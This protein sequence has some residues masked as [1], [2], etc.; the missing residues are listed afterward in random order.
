MRFRVRVYGL[1]LVIYPGYLFLLKKL[2]HSSFLGVSRSVEGRQL[3]VLER[4][5]RS[6]LAS[7]KCCKTFLWPRTSSGSDQS[8]RSLNSTRTAFLFR[9]LGKSIPSPAVSMR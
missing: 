2:F 9:S 7:P 6:V 1:H 4:R 5:R 3:L 8:F